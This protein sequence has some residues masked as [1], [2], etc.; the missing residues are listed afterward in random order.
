MKTESAPEKPAY[1]EL[2]RRV[3]DLESRLAECAG[4]E[5]ERERMKA[6][7]AEAT[8]YGAAGSLAR[9]IVHELNNVLGVILGISEMG[10]ETSRPETAQAKSYARLHESAVRARDLVRQIP[11]SYQK[12]QEKTSLDIGLIVKGAVKFLEG[13]LPLDVDLDIDVPAGLGTVKAVP[14]RVHQLM[15]YLGGIAAQ[16]LDATGGT[17]S[18]SLARVRPETP[19]PPPGADSFLRLSALFRRPAGASC[20]PPLAA[21]ADPEQN[22]HIIHIEEIMAE[23]GGFCEISANGEELGFAMHFPGESGQGQAQSGRESLPRGTERILFVEDEPLLAEL[24]TDV[25]KDLG[26]EVDTALSGRDA[27]ALFSAD[28][29]RY[30]LVMTDRTMPIMPG[31]RLARAI[32]KIRPGVPIIMC[33]GHSGLMTQEML[34]ANH[35]TACL[36]K[37]LGFR[38][39][40]ETL[41][42]VLD[43]TASQD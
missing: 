42:R 38:E 25:L 2:E 19:G 35:L 31:E 32:H 7:L 23:H 18:V 15:V 40:A 26:Y 14:V 4:W 22:R 20:A 5:A 29:A 3:R 37:P 39:V 6:R 16:A 13:S 24:W 21:L 1:E 30:D 27:L 34:A 11:A 41:R 33:T 28:P 8:R 10:V 36:Q 43:E 9:G 12:A 17:F